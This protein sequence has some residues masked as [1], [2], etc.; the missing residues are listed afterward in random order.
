MENTIKSFVKQVIMANGKNENLLIRTDKIQQSAKN[1][2]ISNFDIFEVIHLWENK[3]LI[4]IN[5]VASQGIQ[6]SERSHW[7]ELCDQFTRYNI[8]VLKPE[9]FNIAHV[10]DPNWAIKAY[11]DFQSNKFII[12][13]N[14]IDE[15]KRITITPSFNKQKSKIITVLKKLQEF[16]SDET[17]RYCEISQQE[18]AKPRETVRE[19]FRRFCPEL[20]LLLF[21]FDVGGYRGISST[22]IY[23][24]D[25]E[26]EGIKSISI[27]IKER[28]LTD[29]NKY[30]CKFDKKGNFSGWH[31]AW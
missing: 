3:E 28:G 31:K 11:A 23:A 15:E 14:G 4:K 10:D 22:I 16:K 25:L 13:F 6:Y 24:R 17:H 19:F 20:F 21:K 30:Y 18:C 9:Y 12:K 27:K 5:S 7:L 1:M 29:D 26:K 2:E 8:D